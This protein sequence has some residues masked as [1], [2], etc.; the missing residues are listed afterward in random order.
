MLAGVFSASLA[1]LIA[2]FASAA[3]PPPAAAAVS[4][5]PTLSGVLL[6]PA[7]SPPTTQMP[8]NGQ[9]PHLAGMHVLCVALPCIDESV[10]DLCRTGRWWVPE[11]MPRKPQRWPC[12]EFDTL[13]EAAGTFTGIQLGPLNVSSISALQHMRTAASLSTGSAA[14]PAP[15]PVPAATQHCN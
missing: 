15:A 14:A 10:D 11:S 9:L 7:P 3:M 5:A 6:G 13:V 2:T 12:I 8:V 4:P 1:L